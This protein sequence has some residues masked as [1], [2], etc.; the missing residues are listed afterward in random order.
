MTKLLPKGL[1]RRE[2]Q[3]MTIL[4]DREQATV[5]EIQ[6]LLPDPPSYSAVRRLVAILEEKGHVKHTEVD[7]RYVYNPVESWTEASRSALQ[8]V[9]QIFFGGSVE[10]VV[11][12][13]LTDEET[14]LKPDEI[15]RLKRLIEASKTEEG[16]E[17]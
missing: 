9:M 12:T 5:A 16:D 15:H 6:A 8:Q 10:K 3:I 7:G 13:L 17:Q 4:Y 2:R 1:S 11:T 14:Q